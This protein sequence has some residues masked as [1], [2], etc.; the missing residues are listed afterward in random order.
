[1]YGS[2]GPWTLTPSLYKCTKDLMKVTAFIFNAANKVSH[3][4]CLSIHGMLQHITF[5]Y[6][7][8]KHIVAQRTV[9]MFYC[10]GKINLAQNEYSM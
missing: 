3:K 9:P 10:F 5:I 6:K 8:A 1:M 2:Y 7:M 4:E